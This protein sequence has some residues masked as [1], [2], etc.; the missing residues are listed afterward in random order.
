MRARFRNNLAL[1]NG[2]D[3]RPFR[4]SASLGIAIYDPR[5]RL[6]TIEELLAEADQRMYTVKERR[7]LDGTLPLERIR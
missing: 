3:A 7:R 4:L 5:K 2:D 1:L 6:R